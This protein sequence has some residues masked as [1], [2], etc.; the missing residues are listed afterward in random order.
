[1]R[2]DRPGSG[3]LFEQLLSSLDKGNEVFQVVAQQDAVLVLATI[4]ERLHLGS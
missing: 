2:G 1:M 4:L 3:K